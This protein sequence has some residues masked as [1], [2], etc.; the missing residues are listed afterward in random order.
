MRERLRKDQ[1]RALCGLLGRDPRSNVT[2]EA[3][4]TA[5]RAEEIRADGLTTFIPEHVAATSRHEVRVTTSQD[6]A[7]TVIQ[8]KLALEN[9]DSFVLSRV[10]VPGAACSWLDLR[11]EHGRF[12]G[13]ERDTQPRATQVERL[14]HVFLPGF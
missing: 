7:V 8:D 13:R 11:L 2:E 4:E 10:R 1:A 9:N 5:G 14:V 3:L 6:T 12:I